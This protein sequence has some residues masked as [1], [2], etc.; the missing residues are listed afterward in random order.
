VLANGCINILKHNGN[1]WSIELYN[2]TV[3]QNL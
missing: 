3:S 1:K 2:Q